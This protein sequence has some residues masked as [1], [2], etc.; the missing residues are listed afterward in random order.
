MSENTIAID[1]GTSRTKVAYLDPG[2]QQPELMPLGR[3]PSIPSLFNVDPDSEKV[4]IGDDA[5]DRLED[6]PRCTITTLK[7]ALSQSFRFG[8]RRVTPK[9]LLT[10]LFSEIRERAGREISCFDNVPPT[11]VQ[12]TFTYV[13]PEIEKN[14]LKEAAQAAGFKTVE[15]VSEP[16]AAARAWQAAVSDNHYRDAI[17]LDCGGGTVDW[18]YLHRTESGR[19]QQKPALTQGEVKRGGEEVD[20]D[21][22]E[23]VNSKLPHRASNVHF[24]RQ[25]C[26][27][28]KERYCRERGEQSL[29]QIEDGGHPVKLAGSEI[30]AVIN[31]TFITPVC[32]AFKSYLDD[33][34][35][36]TKRE[37][38]AVL[39]VGGSANL[40]GLKEALEGEL[41]CQVFKWHRSEFATVLGAALPVQTEQVQT[42]Q[43][44]LEPDGED[45][46]TETLYTLTKQNVL[47]VADEFLT[48]AAENDEE[49]AEVIRG[50]L[51]AY[52]S[53]AFRLVVAGEINKGKSSFINSLLD[54]WNLLP[55][56]TGVATSTVYEVQYGQPEKC[57]VHFNLREHS[58]DATQLEEV[59]PREIAL[60]AVAT[61]GTE[62]G[63]PGNEQ[64]VESIVVELPNEF[65]KSGVTLIDTPG[66]GGLVASHADITWKQA[67]RADAF[68]FVLDSLESVVS[69]PELM[70]FSK[71]LEVPEKLGVGR[72]P[73]FFVQ[74]KTDAP[75]DSDAWESCRDRNL[76]SLSAHFDTS[77]EALRYFPVSSTLKQRAYQ[78]VS[79][80]TLHSRM[81]EDSG[82][83]PLEKFF[84]EELLRGK[85]EQS[86][87]RLLQ[88]ILAAT[89]PIGHKIGEELQLFQKTDPADLEELAQQATDTESRLA[90]WAE[91]KYPQLVKHFNA[92]AEELRQETHAQLQTALDAEE[93]GTIIE[94]II[95]ALRDQEL[96]RKELA[97]KS[98]ALQ[99]EC[100]AKCQEVTLSV[101]EQHH[102]K[103][104]ALLERTT[105]ELGSSLEDTLASA[106]I[107]LTPHE[108]EG[109]AGAGSSSF[110]EKAAAVG[111]TAG[112]VLVGD[113]GG[114]VIKLPIAIA[115]GLAGVGAMTTAIVLFPIGLATMVFG[116][117]FALRKFRKS[118]QEAAL[119]EVGRFLSEVVQQ[120]R[121][122]ALQHFEESS[123][124]IEGKVREFLE[125]AK[126]ET[127][128]ELANRRDSIEAAQQQRTEEKQQTAAELEETAGQVAELLQRIEQML[129]TETRATSMPNKS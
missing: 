124:E 125:M 61:Y 10:T 18:C 106:E 116:G 119:S 28:L 122:Q 127:A 72:P 53:D 42:E 54:E 52:R 121:T 66:L 90:T 15:L 30:Q 5:F 73:F 94:P 46:Q 9:A 2:T 41:G 91:E 97:A 3:E 32:G 100:V 22:V 47:Q 80:A 36:A 115:L 84:R 99:Q 59:V 26:R 70:N 65:L 31:D 103:L 86:A 105:A 23:L 69:R 76:E 102:E 27:E 62:S 108:G 82:F 44:M 55:V 120:A 126:T 71:F 12:L 35:E 79:V 104:G 123:T 57:T 19:F 43:P 11:A 17:V 98:E 49:P 68:C 6:N 8:G 67:S 113:V 88:L 33:V 89:R 48:L 25:H 92:S 45:G 34:K 40:K 107:S 74:T 83:L 13:N 85:E 29:F 111:V 14:L 16:E 110:W 81:L 128:K 87:Q 51:E 101:L 117:R 60:E 129:D 39:L 24:L 93:T 63:N 38:P 4:W 7:R 37:D 1:F 96:S 56:E 114:I 75:Q 20:E 58:E 64:E 118:R 77:P 78:E 21:L 109:L 112:G 50:Q 95:A